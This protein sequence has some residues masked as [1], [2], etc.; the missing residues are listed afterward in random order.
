MEMDQVWAFNASSLSLS[1]SVFVRFGIEK[2]RRR[3][4]KSVDERS[5]MINCLEGDR[6]QEMRAT[7]LGFEGTETVVQWRIVITNDE[8]AIYTYTLSTLSPLQLCRQ[9]YS[10]IEGKERLAYPRDNNAEI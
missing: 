3:E 7:E 8:S 4:K 5:R 9:N 2:R 1:P 6:F 10:W